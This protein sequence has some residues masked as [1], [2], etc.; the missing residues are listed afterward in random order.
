MRKIHKSNQPPILAEIWERLY[1]GKNSCPKNLASVC[2]ICPKKSP[3]VDYCVW[4]LPQTPKTATNNPSTA[5]EKYIDAEYI[6]FGTDETYKVK[7]KE[8]LQDALAKEQGY[9]CCYCMQA[10]PRGTNNELVMRIEHFKPQSI[11]NHTTPPDLTVK[12]NNLLAACENTQEK[13]NSHLHHCDVSKGNIVAQHLQNPALSDNKIYYSNSG[14]IYSK[15]IGINEEIGGIVVSNG[16]FGKGLLNLN[17]QT[18][19]NNRK[20]AWN[21]VHKQICKGVGIKDTQNWLDELKRKAHTAITEIQ[22]RIQCYSKKV[23]GQFL[24]FYGYVLW[25]LEQLLAKIKQ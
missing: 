11:F 19:K 20:S 10:L 8:I 2:C 23:K 6:P 4:V 17:G 5:Y 9:V 22:H 3:C 13:G 25:E 18:I 16:V 7:P 15:E 12:Y 1:G 24:P 21:T 14:A